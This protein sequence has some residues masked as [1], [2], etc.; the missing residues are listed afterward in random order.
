MLKLCN[1]INTEFSA[2]YISCQLLTTVKLKIYKGPKYLQKC[3]GENLKSCIILFKSN[4]EVFIHEPCKLPS[5]CI[6]RITK[7]YRYKGNML[8][9]DYHSTLLQTKGYKNLIQKIV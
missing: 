3:Q 9:S 2:S 6:G 7:H 5:K 8:C 1:V 4:S